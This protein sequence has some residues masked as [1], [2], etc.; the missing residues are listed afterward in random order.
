MQDCRENYMTRY[1]RGFGAVCVVVALMS[2][3]GDDKHPAPEVQATNPPGSV[4]SAEKEKALATLKQRGM[5]IDGAGLYS[6][7]AA[8][9][10]ELVNL[11]LETGID[12][13]ARD[14][15]QR[16][17]LQVVAAG[18]NVP[19]GELLLSKGAD[20]NAVD[21]NGTSAVMDAAWEGNLAMVRLLAERG[22]QL[23]IKNKSGYSP[24][25]AA[26]DRNHKEVVDLL[27]SKGAT[28]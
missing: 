10:F 25:R 3:C 9:S 27:V 4:S 15:H 24:L 14:A 12:V 17:A 20:V 23:S 6:A 18:G 16:T 22:A 2:G 26:R 11:Y 5:S 13:N 28:E 1:A 7:A 8:G 21:E 19:L